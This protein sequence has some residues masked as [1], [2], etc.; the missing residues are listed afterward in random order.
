M[1]SVDFQPI[2]RLQ[3]EARWDEAGERLAAAAR[4]LERGGADCVVLCTNTMHK[5]AAQVEAAVMLPLLHVADATGRAVRAAGIAR[6]GLLGT[7]FTMEQAFYRDRLRDVHGLLVTTPPADERATVHRIIY[8]E[9]CR[10]RVE[11]A[12][13]AALR[14][15]AAGLVAG[16]AEGVVLGCTELMLA[17]GPG[18]VSAPLFDTTAL[19][20]AAAVEFALAAQ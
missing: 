13:V 12:S 10:G 19:H 4:A 20:A 9:L 7:R 16:G 6:V 18:D 3:A 1:Y 17:L 11:P 2:E 14:Q 8:D 15:I 5:V